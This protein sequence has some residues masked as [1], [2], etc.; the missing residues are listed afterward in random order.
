MT[1]SPKHTPLPWR[2][3]NGETIVGN[4]DKLLDY[5]NND[6]SVEIAEGVY[7]EN[8]E[9]IVRACNSHYELFDALDRILDEI[10]GIAFG[11]IREFS[12]HVLIK[13]K[14]A[15]VKAKGE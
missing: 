3:F 5:S 14:A 15:I 2:V 13:A 1:Q 11:N 6:S 10:D 7:C 9:F 4:D 8:A 12:Q